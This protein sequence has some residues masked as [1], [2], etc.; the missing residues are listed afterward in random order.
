MTIVKRAMSFLSRRFDV[1]RL[2]ADS[3]SG[4]ARRVVFVGPD[5]GLPHSRA[6][7]GR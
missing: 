6:P 3:E 2:A 7:T 1:P 4:I 5:T